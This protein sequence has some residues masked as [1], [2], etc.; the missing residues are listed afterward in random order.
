LPTGVLDIGDRFEEKLKSGP[1]WCKE[2]LART[3][4]LESKLKNI[5]DGVKNILDAMEQ[6]IL[7]RL[8]AIERIERQAGEQQE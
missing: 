2:I 6:K 4:A 7:P 5:K 8:K 1:E 3:S